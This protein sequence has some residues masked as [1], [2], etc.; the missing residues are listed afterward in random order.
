MPYN[1]FMSRRVRQQ[2]TLALAVFGWLAQLCLPVAHAAAMSTSKAGVATWCGVGSRALQAKLAEL[3]E[4]IREILERGATQAE[5]QD[6][7][8]Q[9]C[10]SVAGGSPLVAAA[11][12]DLDPAVL[13][14]PVAKPIPLSLRAQGAPPPARGPP[15]FSSS[16]S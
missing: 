4:S 3:P 6:R 1:P 16:R 12:I 5:Q 11:S 8:A 13:D 2:L 10:A 9:L 15:D 7:C 14:A